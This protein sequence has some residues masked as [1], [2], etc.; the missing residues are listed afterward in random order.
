MSLV[1][2]LDPAANL[3]ERRRTNY[4]K[5]LQEY[6]I[7]KIQIMES[8]QIKW[9]RLFNRHFKNGRR[10]QTK[11]CH[12]RVE[13]VSTS[14]QTSLKYASS[15]RHPYWQ[16][17]QYHS[18]K[19]FELY[20]LSLMKKGGITATGNDFSVFNEHLRQPSQGQQGQSVPEAA[21]T[22]VRALV[23]S[24]NFSASIFG[25]KLS[26]TVVPHW[27]LKI[28]PGFNAE[29]HQNTRN[30]APPGLYTKTQDLANAPNV[31]DIL[32]IEFK[33]GVPV[34]KTNVKD[35]T[36]HQT[37]LELFMYLS[38]VAGKHGVG[39]TDVVENRFI[40]MK[41]R[42][43]Y[44]TP[45]STI[46]Y[47]TY[48][49]IE[50]FTM[51]WEV[52]KIKQG[53]SLKFAELMYTAFWHSPECEFVH[54]CIAKSE[55]RVE[56]KVQVSVLKGQVYILSWESPLSLYNKELVSMNMQGDYEP[57]DSTGFININSLRLKE[58]HLQRKVTA[59]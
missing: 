17:K 37:S 51:D 13:P 42:G 1:K 4:C 22:V 30:Q 41:S 21:V 36:T 35:G 20:N 14:C 45:A 6:E 18:L 38:Q 11:C 12:I 10:K 31:P 15:K 39:R 47:R 19:G 33:K 56:G 9:Q 40:R 34:K 43:I 49:D 50:A 24:E 58:Y 27:N 55:E 59:K 44:E 7:N 48:L 29:A 16:V 23:S 5:L 8:L 2:A 52:R 26:S 32:E 28:V 53:L 57:I 46:L 3:K 25:S 54:H